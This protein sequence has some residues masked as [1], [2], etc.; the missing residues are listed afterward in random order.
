MTQKL[1]TMIREGCLLWGQFPKVKTK[2]QVRSAASR[3]AWRT[4]KK[5][6]DARAAANQEGKAA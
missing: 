3:K 2:V 5:Q 6:A 4:R 1:S